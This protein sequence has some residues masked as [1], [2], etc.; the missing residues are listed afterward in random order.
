MRQYLE[1]RRDAGRTHVA[2]SA[3]SVRALP[4]LEA[5]LERRLAAG[6]EVVA[7]DAA[8]AEGGVGAGTVA[9]GT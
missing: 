8:A 9:E 6:G 7:G 2:I 4:G 3:E 5:R 1:A